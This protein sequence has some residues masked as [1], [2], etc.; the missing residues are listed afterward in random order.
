MTDL[1][2][3]FKTAGGRAK[4]KELGLGHIY[5]CITLAEYMKNHSIYFL[6][7]DYGGVKNVLKDNKI[8]CVYDLC[9]NPTV[10]HELQ[11]TLDLIK[12]K[13][14]DILIIDRFK[15]KNSYVR[16]I[17]KFVKTVVISDLK[18]INYDADL[19][20]NGF[21][22]FKNSI[23]KNKYGVTCIVGPKYQILNKKYE[24]KATQKRKKFDLLI[25]MGGFDNNR[26]TEVISKEII[27][28]LDNLKVKMILGPATTKSKIIR[29]LGSKFKDNLVV[30]QKTNNMRQEI[31]DSKFGICGGGITSYEF[32][33]VGVPFAIIC[34]YPHQLQTAMQWQKNKIGLN[35]GLPNKHL[36]KKLRSLFNNI[37]SGNIPTQSKKIKVD[38]L[39]ARR[40][41]KIILSEVP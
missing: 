11:K 26:I 29:Q 1:N 16:A 5:R 23:R 2:I 37:L 4:N 31:L 24:K 35:L 10:K 12:E 15:T 30:I 34:Q 33:N 39:G 14:I 8:F 13:N 18:N 6:V 20:I 7:E 3:L 25:T 27:R 9:K 22:G 41:S 32:T 38:G 17:K 40:V 19:V 28:F 21:V 36:G